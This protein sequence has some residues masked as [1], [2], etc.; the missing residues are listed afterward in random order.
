MTIRI[1][2]ILVSITLIGILLWG[3]DWSDITG[4]LQGLDP[5]LAI[6]SFFFLSIQYPV[7]AW[8]WQKA[9]RLHGVYQPYGRLLRVLCI[10][11]FF[12]NF[13][14]T[15]IGGDAYRAF[16][17]FEHSARP[18]HAISAV[19]LERLLGILAL[20]FL[21]Y[22]SAIY[23]VAF[24]N[25]VHREWV[26][27]G[28]ILIA[29]GCLI[30]AIAWRLDLPIV[31]RFWRR[32][33]R[34]RKL[35]PFFDSIRAIRRNREHLPGLIGLSLL[36]QAIAVFTVS[37][38]FASIGLAGQLAESGFTAAAAGAAGVLPISINGVGV[39]EGSFVVAAIE[40]GLP[41]SESV[42]VAICLR[43]YM[44]LSSIAFGV[45]YAL[46]PKEKPQLSEDNV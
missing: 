13:L 22:V 2:K 17:T 37:L 5:M 14:P 30:F 29:L 42:L 26:A 44:L 20:L 36:F 23:L 19:V 6:G 7:S 28:L 12:N 41:Y 21:G 3:V 38:L 27:A 31:R 39:V 45:L 33:M 32:L 15:A 4:R 24:G 35:E 40:A 16:R 18:A 1:L 9:L 11:F 34:F 43:A 8:K 46:E 10:A 25:L